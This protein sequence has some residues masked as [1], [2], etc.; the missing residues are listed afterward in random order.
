MSRLDSMMLSLK[1]EVNP[2]ERAS[3]EVHIRRI[4]IELSVSLGKAT[5]DVEE[6]LQ[7]E[8]GDVIQL[9]THIR[10]PLTLYLEDKEY[11]HVKP[12]VSKGRYAVELEEELDKEDER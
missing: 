1:T 9:G 6:I 10:E 4:P 12:G 5:L 11:Y 7:L 3:M 2:K 8:Q